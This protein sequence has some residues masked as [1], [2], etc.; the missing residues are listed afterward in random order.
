MTTQTRPRTRATA[1][2]TRNQATT[3]R[4]GR[5]P[6][7]TGDPRTDKA[8]PTQ[9]KPT[10]DPAPESPAMSREAQILEQLSGMERG[11]RATIDGA[12][13]SRTAKGYTVRI[14]SV[15]KSYPTASP[16]QRSIS[17]GEH[18]PVFVEEP[19]PEPTPATPAPGQEVAENAAPTHAY[20][21]VN[22]D[23]RVHKAGCRDLKKEI[24]QS[25]YP[26]PYPFSPVSES[27]AIRQLWE[28]Q[29]GDY[30]KKA[31]EVSDDFLHEHSFVSSTSFAPCCGLEPMSAGEAAP[32]QDAKAR[33]ATAKRELARALVLSLSAYWDHVGSQAEGENGITEPWADVY[34]LEEAK[35]VMSQW[36][37]HLP[38]HTPGKPGEW[39]PENMPRPN[40]SDWKIRI[41]QAET[42]NRAR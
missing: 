23:F 13:V 21:L 38:V 18:V 28:D 35:D 24:Q 11:A 8:A 34:S 29:I 1:R 10:T 32:K 26:R 27:D 16:A 9:S 2:D 33:R 3:V 41:A 39:W 12:A 5:K 15:S 4:A 22:G 17:A 37:H 19:T 31:D 36:L 40:R 6:P 7:K 30:G 20:V 14:K 25:D 42:R